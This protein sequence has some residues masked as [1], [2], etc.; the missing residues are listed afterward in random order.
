MA[1]MGPSKKVSTVP[2][3]ETQTKA[4]PAAR[5]IFLNQSYTTK[6]TCF[7][8]NIKQ[9]PISF[10][11]S[12]AVVYALERLLRE[13][14]SPS[15]DNLEELIKTEIIL[16]NSTLIL[17][18]FTGAIGLCER[19]FEDEAGRLTLEKNLALIYGGFQEQGPFTPLPVHRLK[20]LTKRLIPKR[21]WFHHKNSVLASDQVGYRTLEEWC[22]ASHFMTSGQQQRAVNR[23]I[24]EK[25]VCEYHSKTKMVMELTNP[26]H[27]RM[28][29]TG[30][31]LNK[32]ELS[33]ERI[34]LQK[35]WKSGLNGIARLV[36]KEES[37]REQSKRYTTFLTNGFGARNA[38]RSVNSLI[39][40]VH[41][42]DRNTQ[43][44]AETSAELRSQIRGID[45]LYGQGIKERDSNLSRKVS[46][47]KAEDISKDT[48]E[49]RYRLKRGHEELATEASLAKI[50]KRLASIETCTHEMFKVL[51]QLKT[52][53][54][55]RRTDNETRTPAKMDM[56][57]GREDT[58]E[59]TVARESDALQ[60]AMNG[61]NL[62]NQVDVNLTEEE[63]PLNEKVELHIPENSTL[64]GVLPELDLDTDSFDNL[65][66]YLLSA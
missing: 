62:E 40:R 48:S 60:K 32:N 17:T 59:V 9:D 11:W 51:L 16:V 7:L 36:G 31:Y 27:H 30:A 64:N 44:R 12:T 24:Y 54:I 33:L 46:A 29:I 38:H 5:N 56:E 55:Q 8:C 21:G 6:P 2:E 10:A 61:I 4:K 43:A 53:S 47:E 50:G 3:K 35:M 41:D 52:D 14:L 58:I 57:I 63:I 49:K 66:E 25:P 65:E 15:M 28:I 39:R 22:G 19:C 1:R 23:Q 13:G 34:H 26:S 20:H 45:D 18:S 42:Q 37:I